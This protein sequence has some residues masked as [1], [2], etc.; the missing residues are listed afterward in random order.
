[1]FLQLGTYRFE[2]AKLP[3]SW[4]GNFETNYVQIPI[5]NGKAVVQSTGE[6]LNELEIGALF[7]EEFG[8]VPMDE[9]EKLQLSRRNKEVLQLTGGD[10]VNYGRYVITKCPVTFKRFKANGYVDQCSISLSL[11]EY[12][13]TRTTVRVEGEALVSME[14]ITELP[15][16]P[17]V[18]VASSINQDINGG[19]QKSKQISTETNKDSIDFSKIESLA[20]TVNELWVSANDKIQDTKKIIYKTV[21]LQNVIENGIDAAELVRQA[22]EIENVNDLYAAN[23]ILEQ[24]NYEI[25]GAFSPIIAFE[26]SR[27]GGE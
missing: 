22:A 17:S 16:L 6:K 8:Y 23:T 10:G 13:T 1:M 3:E 25:N 11:L 9:V 12:N 20:T 4:T 2:G 27:E 15:G 24:A 18:Q 14:P 7:S 5:I 21:Q 19:I 26:G